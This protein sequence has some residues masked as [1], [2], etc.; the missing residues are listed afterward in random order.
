MNQPMFTF[1]PDGKSIYAFS[2]GAGTLKA[3]VAVAL[4]FL[5]MMALALVQLATL[6]MSMVNFLLTSDMSVLVRF[7]AFLIS[8]ALVWAGITYLQVRFAAVGNCPQEAK[9]TT[10]RVE[11]TSVEEEKEA[12]HA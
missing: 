5:V 9:Q 1:S 11:E 7:L 3:V 8:I 2:P 6:A 12:S 10:N 4:S